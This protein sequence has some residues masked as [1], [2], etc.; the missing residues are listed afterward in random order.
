MR[1]DKYKYTGKKKYKG[2][3]FSTNETGEFENKIDGMEQ[4]YENLSRI[5]ELQQYI[6]ADRKEG[7]IFIFQAMDAAGKDGAIRAVLSCLS[8][9]GVT[10]SSFKQPTK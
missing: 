8:P 7:V 9:L 1:L 5:N 3:E 6:Y 2:H 4:F 10:E